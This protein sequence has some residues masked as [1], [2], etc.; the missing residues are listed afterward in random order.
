MQ[1]LFGVM[2]GRNWCGK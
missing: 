1:T 2:K